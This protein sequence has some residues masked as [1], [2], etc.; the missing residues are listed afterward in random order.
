MPP[1]GRSASAPWCWRSPSARAR[2]ALE[3][4]QR[5][6]EARVR[7][8]TAALAASELRYR[9]LVETVRDVVFALDQQG[10]ITY[11][12]PAI[13]LVAGYAPAELL[14]R[15]FVT[16]LHPDDVAPARASFEDS[17]DGQGGPTRDAW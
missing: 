11:V 5:Q 16:V 1:A 8:R 15:P 14:G 3:E 17:L 6:L 9:E 12:S 13:G 2:R 7:E 4:A 10:A